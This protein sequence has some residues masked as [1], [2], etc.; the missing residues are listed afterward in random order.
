MVSEI[1]LL[2]FYAKFRP[3]VSEMRFYGIFRYVHEF[4]NFFG[5]FVV[6]Y[7][8]CHTSFHRFAV[9]WVM[10]ML[11]GEWFSCLFYFLYRA[12]M[13]FTVAW[14]AWFVG[15]PVTFR[16]VGQFPEIGGRINQYYRVVIGIYNIKRL[17][18]RI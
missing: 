15:Q 8:V 18:K 14:F 17:R 13:I 12:W 7:H 9:L 5:G 2:V 16:F 10:D 6:F 4:C 1:D 11:Y 3:Y